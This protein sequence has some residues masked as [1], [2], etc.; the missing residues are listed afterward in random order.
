M[1]TANVTNQ[2][3]VVLRKQLSLGQKRVDLA[4]NVCDVYTDCALATI[5]L[6]TTS[7]LLGQPVL[8]RPLLCLMLSLK[9]LPLLMQMKTGEFGWHSAAYSFTFR[10]S[11]RKTMEVRWAATR[12]CPSFL[13]PKVMYAYDLSGK[14]VGRMQL[15]ELSRRTKASLT[16]KY[17]V[18]V[19]RRHCTEHARPFFM[20]QEPDGEYFS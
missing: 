14:R 20:P 8:D 19:S 15:T 6:A 7:S 12:G 11:P 16:E 5:Q 10:A 2:T 13:N 1:M 18:V 4:V 3:N 9:A 17:A